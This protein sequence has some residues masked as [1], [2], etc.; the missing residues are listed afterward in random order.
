M[1]LT[2]PTLSVADSVQRLMYLAMTKVTGTDL[3]QIL[4]VIGVTTAGINTMADLLN[5]VKL[6]PNSYL[7]LT[8]TTATGPRAVYINSSGAVDSNLE[9]E[10][11]AYVIGPV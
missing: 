10:L 3:A 7:S 11:P 1:N 5:P 2:S 4:K 6:F 8:V 9:Q